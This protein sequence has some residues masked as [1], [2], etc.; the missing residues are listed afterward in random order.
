MNHEMPAK[1]LM[2]KFFNDH[3]H[4]QKF[5]LDVGIMLLCISESLGDEN[6]WLAIL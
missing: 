2:M 4:G 5:S 6:H 1:N 3:D